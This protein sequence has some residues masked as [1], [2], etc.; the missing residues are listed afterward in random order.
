MTDVQD[1]K[2]RFRPGDEV[3]LQ[4]IQ[5]E[6]NMPSG[7][8][9]RVT[10]VDD[11][12][13]IHVDWENGSSMPLDPEKDKFTKDIREHIKVVLVEPGKEARTAEIEDSLESMQ[14]LVGGH[15]EEYMPFE[16]DAAVICNEDGK[17]NG[18]P[19]NRAVYGEDGRIADIIAGPFFIC[20][21]PLE[22]ERLRSL[23]E[24]MEKKYLEK[25]REPERFSKTEYGIKAVKY[26]ECG[27]RQAERG[28]R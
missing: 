16:D 2:E 15:I 10:S 24:D 12:G 13:R 18:M 27:K 25:F 20:Y 14:A 11:A 4:R 17:I 1:I 3:T 23:P 28:C 6:I 26:S 7:L 5:G 22:S 8:K 21:A 9:G 19:L